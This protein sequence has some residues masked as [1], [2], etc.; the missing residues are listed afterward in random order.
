MQFLVKIKIKKFQPL[1]AKNSQAISLTLIIRLIIKCISS[2]LSLFHHLVF[3]I[4]AQM[5]VCF[6][7]HKTA[8]FHFHSLYEL[9]FSP[10]NSF[11][12]PPFLFLL[13]TH[14]NPLHICFFLYMPEIFIVTSPF[15]ESSEMKIIIVSD[16]F[17]WVVEGIISYIFFSICFL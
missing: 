5:C 6:V 15:S 2:P 12:P 17:A 4:L 10:A 3:M 9:L 8:H 1:I 13:F 7:K 16:T 11:S 14:H